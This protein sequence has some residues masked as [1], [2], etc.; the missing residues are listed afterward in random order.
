MASGKLLVGLVLMCRN[1]QDVLGHVVWSDTVSSSRI[2]SGRFCKTVQ[3]IQVSQ[4]FRIFSHVVL[5]TSFTYDDIHQNPMSY[6]APT[7]LRL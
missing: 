6:K 5:H 7:L 4:Y 1:S 3:L 2:L